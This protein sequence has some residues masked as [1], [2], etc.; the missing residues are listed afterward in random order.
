MVAEVVLEEG[1]VV[2]VRGLRGVEKGPEIVDEVAGESYFQVVNCRVVAGLRH[3]ANAVKNALRAFKHG[4]NIAKKPSIEF[5]ICLTAKRQIRDAIQAAS[6]SPGDDVL[7]VVFGERKEDCM[8][9]IQRLEEA[10]GGVPD[11]EIVKPDEERTRYLR[12]FF[13]ISDEELKSVSGDSRA[14]ESLIIERGAL[15]YVSKT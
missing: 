14:L 10:L 9:T 1:V 7:L 3:V 4:Y 15:V 11:D 2:L 5:L 6:F 8:K 12:K 13:A